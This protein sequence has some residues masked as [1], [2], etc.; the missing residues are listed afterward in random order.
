MPTSRI[1]A[2][3]EIMLGKPVIRGTRLTV[4]LLL[5]KMSEGATVTDLLRVYPQLDAAAVEAALDYA[6]ASGS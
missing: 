5:R 4:E 3:H 1:T 2:S 6:A